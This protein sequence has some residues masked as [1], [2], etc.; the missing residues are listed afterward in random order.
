MYAFIA[1]MSSN[2]ISSSDLG[3]FLILKWLINKKFGKPF[4]RIIALFFILA[5]ALLNASDQE[6]VI[7]H[8]TIDD[9]DHVCEKAKLIESSPYFS[10]LFSSGMKDSEQTRFDMEYSSEAIE[11]YLKFI[12][13]KE[14][15]F[16]FMIHH[17][18]F[19]LYC[20]LKNLAEKYLQD[21]LKVALSNADIPI[22][23]H[24]LLTAFDFAVLYE[25]EKLIENIFGKIKNAQLY[26]NLELV[27]RI[28]QLIKNK[29][30]FIIKHFG[31]MSRGNSSF[32]KSTV[33]HIELERMASSKLLLN[34]RAQKTC[35]WKWFPFEEEE[36][37]DI[38]NRIYAIGG[39]LDKLDKLT[40]KH[41]REYE[42]EHRHECPDGEW[43]FLSWG[44]G[45]KNSTVACL[46]DPPMRSVKKTALNGEKITFTIKD[47]QN[48][49]TKA[50]SSLIK[51]TDFCGT[52]NVLSPELFLQTVMEW[53]ED[54][55]PFMVNTEIDKTAWSFPYDQIM[56]REL[57]GPFMFDPDLELIKVK[58]YRAEMYGSGAHGGC[59]YPKPVYQFY[60]ELDNGEP[61]NSG[62]IK[63]EK[64]K[65]SIPNFMWRPHPVEDLMNKDNWKLTEK[66]DNPEV[67]VS[68]IY[69][70]Y[71]ESLRN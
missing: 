46:L 18:S 47:I 19:D 29:N 71:I 50:I 33:S 10:A 62:W 24:E 37:T 41:S 26:Q 56:I 53:A 51:N 43:P 36:S 40:G 42:Y 34:F 45:D 4:M 69:D 30:Q 8:S 49:L 39:P 60:I 9:T 22:A 23:K 7:F 57:D 17:Q 58:F 2:V 1:C 31:K 16:A 28:L 67:D 44:N 48:L 68:T 21:N 15:K 11:A 3:F 32:F 59:E 13:Q 70:I 55:L 61:I 12:K 38:Y 52:K 5:S 25:D 63:T 65:H 54:I 64:Y 35:Y 66:S 14:K 20:E 27:T 6:I